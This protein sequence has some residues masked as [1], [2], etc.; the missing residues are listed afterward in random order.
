MGVQPSIGL[1]S[2][3][4]HFSREFKALVIRSG[5]YGVDFG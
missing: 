1:V 5:A 2:K 4:S 3:A